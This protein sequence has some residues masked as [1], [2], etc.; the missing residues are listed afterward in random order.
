MQQS[1]RMH[2]RPWRKWKISKQTSNVDIKN[3]TYNN[4]I[5]PYVHVWSYHSC[6][7]HW[8]FSNKN[9]V[10]HMKREECHSEIQEYCWIIAGNYWIEKKLP[11]SKFFKRRSDDRFLAKYT[12]LSH[13][14]IGQVS[15]NHTFTH[16]DILSIENDILRSTKDRLPTH[17]VTSVLKRSWWLVTLKVYTYRFYGTVCTYS[18]VEK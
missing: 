13:T 7:D 10:T 2:L 6:I 8:I 18:P 14:D 12:I 11:F 3:K 4:T 17:L 1:L 5:F 15:S 9:M 16:N